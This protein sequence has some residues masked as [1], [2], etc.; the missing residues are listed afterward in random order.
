MTEDEHRKLFCPDAWV[1]IRFPEGAVSANRDHVGEPL[2]GTLCFGSRCAAWRWVGGDEEYIY[3]HSDRVPNVGA[4][5]H[6]VLEPT[7]DG[8]VR[9][10]IPYFTAHNNVVQKWKRPLSADKRQGFCGKYEPGGAGS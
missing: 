7:G 1:V 6:V 3:T 10:S 2:P 4:L 8:W 5:D 9:S